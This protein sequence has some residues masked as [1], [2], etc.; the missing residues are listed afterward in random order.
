[1]LG[2]RAWIT[3]RIA[4]R[5]GRNLARSLRNKFASVTNGEISRDIL[6]MHDVRFDGHH[7]FDGKFFHIYL[8][9]RVASIEDN[10]RAACI[11]VYRRK[12]HDGSAVRQR[13]ERDFDARGG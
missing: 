7:R 3:V 12:F 10:A 13:A 5:D 2:I 6:Q 9:G 4:K 1:M 11:E 8:I